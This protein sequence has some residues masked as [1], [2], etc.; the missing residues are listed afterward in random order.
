VNGV[1]HNW[2]G[3]RFDLSGLGAPKTEGAQDAVVRVGELFA[4]RRLGRGVPALRRLLVEVMDLGEGYLSFWAGFAQLEELRNLAQQAADT[5]RGEDR[6]F[7]DRFAA[8]MDA[9]RTTLPDFLEPQEIPIDLAAAE[10]AGTPPDVIALAREVAAEH[11]RDEVMFEDIM[12]AE[13][14]WKRGRRPALH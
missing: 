7:L 1:V 8:R 13:A 5:A 11:G 10:K 14:A 3:T 4:M 6:R 2:A 12:A 9:F